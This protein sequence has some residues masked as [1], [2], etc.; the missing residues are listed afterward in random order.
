[1]DIKELISGY[2]NSQYMMQV[3]TESNRQPWICTVYYAVDSDLNLYWLSLPTRKH[4]KEIKINNKIAAAIPVVFVNGEKVVGIQVQ[5]IAE[6]LESSSNFRKIAEL[7]ADIFNRT[8]D[9]VEDFCKNETDHKL[10]KITPKKFVLFDE[11]N[12][13]EDPR[14]EYTL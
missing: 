13:P 2:L 5:G 6:E 11:R 10:Y 12:F 3:A 7:Y 8:K 14:Q 9:W 4:S 1:M